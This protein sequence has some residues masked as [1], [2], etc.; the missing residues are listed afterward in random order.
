MKNSIEWLENLTD[1]EMDALIDEWKLASIEEDLDDPDSLKR[2]FE[3]K[4]E[5]YLLNFISEKE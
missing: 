5:E 2:F 3:D 1:E 4:Y